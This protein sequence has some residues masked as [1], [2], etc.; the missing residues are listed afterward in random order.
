MQA[1]M[2]EFQVFTELVR[3]I[4]YKFETIVRTA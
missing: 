1:K 3:V 2:Q 4:R